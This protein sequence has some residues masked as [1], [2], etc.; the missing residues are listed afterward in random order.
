MSLCQLI[1]KI[2]SLKLLLLGTLSRPANWVLEYCLANGGQVLDRRVCSGPAIVLA[3][4]RFRYYR[5]WLIV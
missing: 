2:L 1:G 5:V 3:F 4:V